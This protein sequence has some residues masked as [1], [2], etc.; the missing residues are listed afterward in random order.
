MFF[1]LRRRSTR[2]SE[3]L[4]DNDHYDPVRYTKEQEYVE[5][6]VKPPLTE[7]LCQ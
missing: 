2:K 4:N 3:R 7:D 6:D 1:L 5:M